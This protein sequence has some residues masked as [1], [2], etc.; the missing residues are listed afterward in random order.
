MLQ[1]GDKVVLFPLSN[2]RY[3]A[4]KSEPIEKGDKVLTISIG[5]KRPIV[6]KPPK[7]SPGDK[8]I[9]IT[10]PSGK[11]VLKYEAIVNDIPKGASVANIPGTLQ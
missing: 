3:A 1:E 11:W 7:L 5:D 6:I 4:V 8:A 2:G 9:V 10:T